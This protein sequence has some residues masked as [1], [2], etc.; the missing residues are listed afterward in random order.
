MTLANSVLVSTIRPTS[1]SGRVDGKKL[2]RVTLLVVPRLPTSKSS[3]LVVDALAI[4]VKAFMVDSSAASSPDS[5][6]LE[7]DGEVL[8]PKI[9]GLGLA[10]VV[11]VV[12]GAKVNRFGRKT[13]ANPVEIVR[14]VVNCEVSGN[15]T[16]FVVCVGGA[17]VGANVKKFGRNIPENPVDMVLPVVMSVASLPSVVVLVVVKVVVVVVSVVVVVVV[18]V[19][20]VGVVDVVDILVVVDSRL[21]PKLSSESVSDTKKFS[22]VVSELSE[23]NPNSSSSVKELF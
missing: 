7:S 23:D 2:G 20:V 16:V 4:S 21:I 13:P 15:V 10:V 9:V 22:V 17:V 5:V 18:E 11:V 1:S 19:V 12:I 14:P 8:N 6:E 3:I